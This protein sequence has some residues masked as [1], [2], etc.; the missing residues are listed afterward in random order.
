LQFSLPAE[1]LAAGLKKMVLL[2]TSTSSMRAVEGWRVGLGDLVNSGLDRGAA[3]RAISVEAAAAMGQEELIAPLESGAPASFVI[4]EGDP[5]NPLA[6]VSH[7][8]AAGEVIY[9]RAKED[10]EN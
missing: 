10:K 4:L 6:R 1:L 7:L 5:L 9:D 2:P 8:V 3:L